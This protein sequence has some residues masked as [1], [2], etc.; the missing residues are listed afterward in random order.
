M[1]RV[2]EVAHGGAD[3]VLGF[4]RLHAAYT[5]HGLELPF[6]ANLTASTVLGTH[7]RKVVIG[8]VE[9]ALRQGCDAVATHVNVS[10]AH[11]AEML[12]ALGQIAE[13][14]EEHELPLLAIMYPRREGTG[15]DDNYLE[16][17]ERDRAAYADLVRHAVRIAVELGADVVKTQYTGDLESFSTVVA[18]SLGV[19]VIVAGGPRTSIHQALANAHGAV[20]AGAAGVCFGRQTYNRRD[21]SG[22]VRFLRAVVREGQDP[23]EFLA[24]SEVAEPTKALT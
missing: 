11:E 22:F 9:R 13:S 3:A 21:V 10:G 15:T 24:R 17:K 14:C 8:S 4:R 18:A 6:V 20:Q 12:A 5:S 23:G 16:L 19:P 1:A 2:Q 7:T